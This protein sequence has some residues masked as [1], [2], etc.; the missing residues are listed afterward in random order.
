MKT[1]AVK[2]ILD[3][4]RPARWALEGWAYKQ[5]RCGEQ[6]KK[7]RN[8]FLGEPM[9]VVGNGPS[10]R[11]TPLDEFIG[12]N[13]IGMNKIDRFF[14]KTKWRPNLVVCSNALV[15]RQNQE[16]FVRSEVPVFISWTTRWYMKR[17]NRERLSYYYTANT[18]KFSTDVAAGIGVLGTVTYAALQWAYYMGANPVVLFGIDHNFAAKGAA[19]S[20][21]RARG[22]DVDHFDSGYFS[23]GQ[24]WQLPDLDASEVGYQRARE[25]FEANG[26]MVY[27]ATIGGKLDVFPKITLEEAKRLCGVNQGIGGEKSGS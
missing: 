20:V 17:A 15:A 21:V 13:S 22:H 6:I 19:H 24:L 11:K 2:I 3:A 25:A 4:V 12:T 23:E 8:V 5:S 9:L 27:D 16:Q 1:P 26:R 14:P 18:P 10:L 7:Y